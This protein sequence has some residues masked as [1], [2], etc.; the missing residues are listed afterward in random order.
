M[1]ATLLKFGY[2]DTVV[3]ALTHW[4]ILL[5][6]QQIT[7][8]SLVLVSNTEARSFGSLPTDAFQELGAV[9]SLIETGLAQFRRFDRINYVMLMM[10]DPHVHFHVLPRYE[11]A[12]DYHGMTFGDTSWPGPPDFK[13]GIIPPDPVKRALVSDLR[14]VMRADNH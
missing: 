10:V 9:T 1:H 4:I 8:G 14:K 11:A 5:R 2:P 6:P 7:L 13:S 12:Q 3:A